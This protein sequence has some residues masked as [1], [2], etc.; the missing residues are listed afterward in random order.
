MRQEGCSW[1][2]RIS[3]KL[4][5]SILKWHQKEILSQSATWSNVKEELNKSFKPTTSSKQLS[6]LISQSQ[7]DR[8]GLR[9]SSK[10]PYNFNRKDVPVSDSSSCLHC[11]CD[12]NLK[13]D[14]LSC[15][16]KHDNLTKSSGEHFNNHKKGHGQQRNWQKK[17]PG[18]AHVPKLKNINWPQWTKKSIITP[19]SFY[20]ELQLKWVPKANT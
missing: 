18:R 8:K 14:C 9:N 5:K 15:K 13:N 4:L 2:L 16:R 3:C 6:N 7:N 20:W 19:L 12:G 10:S 17:G 11:G 1:S